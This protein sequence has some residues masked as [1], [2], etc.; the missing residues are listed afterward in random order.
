VRRDAIVAHD[1]DPLFDAQRGEGVAPPTDS[2]KQL[3]FWLLARRGRA[4]R[5]FLAAEIL[6]GGSAM[7]DDEESNPTPVFERLR[8]WLLG[9]GAA[10]AMGGVYYFLA[11]RG[12]RAVGTVSSRIESADEQEI[13]KLTLAVDA[14]EAEWRE[15][16][17]RGQG[18]A[19]EARAALAS[20]VEKQ[21]QLVRLDVRATPAYSDR[22]RSLEQKMADAEVQENLNRIA[23]LETEALAAR[24]GQRDEEARA[25]MRAAL[26][27]LEAVNRSNAAAARKDL[28]RESRLK[29]DLEMLEAEPLSQIVV[30]ARARAERAARDER[31]EEVRSAFEE[32]RSVQARINREYPR[33]PFVDLAAE[34]QLE[35]QIQSL[36]ATPLARTVRDNLSSGE[37]R[38]RAGR[39]GEAAQHFAQALAAQESINTQFPKSREYSVAALEDLEA[40][41]QTALSMEGLLRLEALD[42]E[43]ARLLRAS[44]VPS[45]LVKITESAGLAAQVW[46]E[47][48]R[49]RRLDT[50]LRERVD[51]RAARG[52]VL[53]G[54][55]E[56]V[57]TQLRALPTHSQKTLRLFAT[58][59]P[60]ALYARVMDKNPSRNVGDAKPV[61]SVDWLEAVEFSR[62][63]GW[64]LGR[65]VRLP[66]EAEYRAVVGDDGLAKS[67]TAL[68]GGVA[69][70]LD[71]PTSDVNASVA[72]GSYLDTAEVLT[73]FPIQRMPKNERARHV[74][75]RIVV[76]D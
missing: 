24:A 69:E 30:R 41:R 40:R 63:L 11:T 46:R 60:Q 14:A 43:I 29:P 74:G 76:V 12:P 53:A 3:S 49:S 70:W 28:P 20:A 52:V 5:C 56:D 4:P 22:L 10:M 73:S 59:V 58:E 1:G 19:P 17:A 67:F 37:E 18:A 2:D 42:A 6:S 36:Q 38:V 62:R 34:D 26:E 75:F 31:W 45:A 44:E 13:K 32:V 68:S 64:L 71:A 9:L 65:E 54:V 8:P 15:A 33:T 55:R 66:T 50:S 61:D 39:H 27:I 21:R 72:G 47:F 25:K 7:A 23:A 16:E 35:T 51:F 57:F 48:P